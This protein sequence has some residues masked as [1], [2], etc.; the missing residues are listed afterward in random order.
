MNVVAALLPNLTAVAP[1]RF[2]PVMVT[3]V[4]PGAGPED[5]FRE[6]HALLGEDVRFEVFK[7]EP[8]PAAPDMSLFDTLGGVLKDLKPLLAMAERELP[9][10]SYIMIRGQVETM[11]ASF[12]GLGVGLAMAIVLLSCCAP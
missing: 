5:M 7:A 3:V 11:N 8:G 2:V 9:R 1:V 12:L 6:L 10:G 4:V